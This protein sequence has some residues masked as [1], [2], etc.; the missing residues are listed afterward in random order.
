MQSINQKMNVLQLSNKNSMRV[1]AND[2]SQTFAKVSLSHSAAIH[3]LRNDNNRLISVR[4][5]NYTSRT[6][7]SRDDEERKGISAIIC[8]LLQYQ[9]TP[10]VDI[11]QLNSNP[12]SYQYPESMLTQVV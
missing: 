12:L 5:T 7:R 9:A 1:K 2:I 8:K 10:E 6:I 11:D 4:I 3:N